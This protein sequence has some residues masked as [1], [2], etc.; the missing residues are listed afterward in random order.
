M[1][2]T[3]MSFGRDPYECKQDW[4]IGTFLQGGNDGV[5]YTGKSLNEAF[6][7]PIGTVKDVLGR[8]E[9]GSVFYRTAFFEAFPRN[10]DT[11]IRGEGKTIEEAETDAWRQY[12]KIRNCAG[13]EF[14]KR[15]RSDGVGWCKHCKMF[16]IHAFEKE[17][18][19]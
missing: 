15:G 9:G 12:E 7:D 3:R 19:P 11:F 14:E 17:L 5:V 10:P 18:A 1:M 13:H 4:P 2:K 8:G 16:S 6:D